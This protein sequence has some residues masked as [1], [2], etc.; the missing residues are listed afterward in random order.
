MLKCGRENC[1][2]C[3]GCQVSVISG[4]FVCKTYSDIQETKK[5]AERLAN[6]GRNAKVVNI[7]A[8]RKATNEAEK[9][10]TFG[11]IFN[12]N[13]IGDKFVC[14][15]DGDI[16]LYHTIC[17]NEDGELEVLVYDF[18]ADG[19]VKT[20]EPTPYSEI[21]LIAN[22]EYV[23]RHRFDDI[24]PEVHIPSIVSLNTQ[25]DMIEIDMAALE[26]ASEET[27]LEIGK[28]LSD[29]GIDLAEESF[30]PYNTRIDENEVLEFVMPNIM[31]TKRFMNNN[32]KGVICNGKIN[33]S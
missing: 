23:V 15:D 7:E 17:S 22:E 6:L 25:Y 16:M 19:F 21:R 27:K 11:S 18:E 28:F 13:H 33:E 10:V 9:L 14:P 8:L 3:P 26:N 29:S 32:I 20:E 24:E 12:S 31:A 30:Y 4:D 2:G 1:I 5:F